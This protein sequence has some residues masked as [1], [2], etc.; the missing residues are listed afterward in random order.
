M[1]NVDGRL[2]ENYVLSELVKLGFSPKY[3]RTKMKTE[4]DFIIEIGSEKIPIEVKMTAEKVEKSLHSYISTY[5]PRRALV[6]TYK[7][8]RKKIT[9][10]GCT[11]LFTDAAQLPELLKR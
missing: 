5:R 10:G 3:W 4:V 11:V 9:L 6:I 7:G 2:F 1:N 8:K